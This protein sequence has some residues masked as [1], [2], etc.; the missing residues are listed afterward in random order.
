MVMRV[1]S[2]HGTRPREARGLEAQLAA[3][4]E[5]LGIGA[6]PVPALLAY[7]SEL[8]K[9]NSAYNLTA[10]RQPQEMV[11]R[12]LL[13]SLVLRPYL[14]GPLLDVGSGAGLPGIPL[15]IADPALPVTVLDSNG[16]KARFLRHVVRTLALGNVTV[17]ETRVEDFHPPQPFAAV[18]SRA[19]ASLAEFIRISGHLLAS[20]GQ[21]LAMKGKLDPQELGGLRE[22]VAILDVHPLTVPGLDEERHLVVAVRR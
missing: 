18:V 22:D 12:H 4:L 2:S 6:A 15:A 21:W 14:R 19:F 10:V 13:D 1:S 8:Q 5:R 16:K 17:A 9:W 3:A 20:D 11:R 7:L